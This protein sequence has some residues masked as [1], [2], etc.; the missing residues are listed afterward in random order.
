MGSILEYLTPDHLGKKQI[1]P[2]ET[3]S[4]STQ[5]SKDAREQVVP[6]ML[7]PPPLKLQ[8][9]CFN[10][11]ET[12]SQE[13]ES[14]CLSSNTFIATGETLQHL[15]E[16]EFESD[17]SLLSVTLDNGTIACSNQLFEHKLCR[18]GSYDCCSSQSV[19]T[20]DDESQGHHSN[21]YEDSHCEPGEAQDNRI[22]L[23]FSSSQS[24]SNENVIIIEPESDTLSLDRTQDKLQQSL[25]ATNLTINPR[26]F[27]PL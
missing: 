23:T 13:S 4:I 19:Q 11:S 17:D 18:T 12:K 26:H 14:D 20:F 24:Y 8:Q 3:T 5:Q 22:I 25:P 1:L 10:M 27:D 21:I 9:E 16:A 2:A 15:H 6:F 7:H